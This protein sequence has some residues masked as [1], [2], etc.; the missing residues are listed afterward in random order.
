MCENRLKIIRKLFDYR[1]MVSQKS[2]TILIREIIHFH[3]T[4]DGRHDVH[5]LCQQKALAFLK[6]V[7]V[8][9]IT[10]FMFGNQV[11]LK[12]LG[13]TCFVLINVKKC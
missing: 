4:I 2:L 10:L 13:C 12:N 7:L 5:C 1:R 8:P 9:L 3:H 6:Q 11:L